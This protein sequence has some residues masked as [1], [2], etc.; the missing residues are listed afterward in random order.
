MDV[1]VIFGSLMSLKAYQSWS[2]GWFVLISNLALI[3]DL[4]ISML[5]TKWF[6][7]LNKNSHLML[8]CQQS[9]LQLPS[10]FLS[11]TLMGSICLCYVDFLLVAF[12][13]GVM[14][15]DWWCRD[16]T[17]SLLWCTHGWAAR[18]AR[19][20]R[21]I[22]MIHYKAMP[23]CYLLW[24]FSQSDRCILS[25]YVVIFCPN[26]SSVSCQIPSHEFASTFSRDV[27]CFST[28]GD[29]HLNLGT[30][31][32]LRGEGC[33]TPGVSFVL[34]REIYPN[35]GCSVKISISRSCLSLFIR[36]SLGSSPNSEI[37]DREK[38]P[39]FERVKTFISRNECRL[40]DQSRLINLVWSS[41][42]QTLDG[43]YLIWARV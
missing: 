36:L 25:Q 41:F 20:S 29:P 16:E 30:R 18:H 8:F 33:D 11:H 38:Q 24:T 12:G 31:F 22:V 7:E 37:I 2:H 40:E 21:L 34:R 27:T 13:N 10:H 32:F 9:L 6:S 4:I 42:N 14:T 1:V 39:I 19:V 3:S 15:N 43:C 17:E 23:M 26:L 35:L 28:L 5:V